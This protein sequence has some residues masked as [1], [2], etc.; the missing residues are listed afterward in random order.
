MKKKKTFKS[1]EILKIM[2]KRNKIKTACTTYIQLTAYKQID[3]EN[4]N[5]INVKR[6]SE[7]K[8]RENPNN[9]ILQ[10]SSAIFQ[11]SCDESIVVIFICLIS[12]NKNKYNISLSNLIS[13][14]KLHL[15]SFVFIMNFGTIV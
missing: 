15:G 2:M 6:I 3:I 13:L 7:R 10:C 14:N 1:S 11:L 8:E 4:H 5:Q 12:E 9:F